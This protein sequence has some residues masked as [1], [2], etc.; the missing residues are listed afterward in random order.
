[1]VWFPG[2]ARNTQGSFQH[3][4]SAL[5]PILNKNIQVQPCLHWF[6]Q[7]WEVD[8]NESPDEPYNCASSHL[9]LYSPQHN[10]DFSPKRTLVMVG[11]VPRSQLFLSEGSVTN[12]APDHQIAALHWGA[13]R[14]RHSKLRDVKCS[15]EKTATYVHLCSEQQSVCVFECTRSKKR[16]I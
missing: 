5:S 4:V 10:A 6:S 11:N 12:P 1:M 13:L 15:S 7:F 3:A 9:S 2:C 16:E 14:V 8:R